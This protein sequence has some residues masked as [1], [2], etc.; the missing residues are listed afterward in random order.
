MNDARKR[1]E[2]ADRHSREL[3]SRLDDRLSDLDSRLSGPGLADEA[4]GLLRERLGPAKPVSGKGRDLVAHLKRH[5]VAGLAAGL[6]VAWFIVTWRLDNAV[7]EPTD[8][9]P[10]Q[11][12]PARPSGAATLGAQNGFSA[13]D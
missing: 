2:E 13:D 9:H 11:E 10:T 7:A 3:R 1:F 12:D 5:P 4:I 8:D 6:A